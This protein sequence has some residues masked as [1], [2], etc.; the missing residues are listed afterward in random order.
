MTRHFTADRPFRC[1]ATSLVIAGVLALG[2]C[3]QP[4]PATG[5]VGVVPEEQTPT[6]TVAALL[7]AGDLTRAAGDLPSAVSFY[8]RA[9]AIAPDQAAPLIRLGETSPPSA[10]ITTRRN[11]SVPPSSAMPRMPTPIAGSATPCWR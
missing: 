7:R 6:K 1:A 10:P 5:Y 11:P 8:R 2:G 9:H 3:A 4:G